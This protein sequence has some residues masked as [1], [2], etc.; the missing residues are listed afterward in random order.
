M[1]LQLGRL[2]VYRDDCE[3]VTV[4]LYSGGTKYIHLY[5]CKVFGVSFVPNTRIIFFFLFWVGGSNIAMEN[6]WAGPWSYKA[7]WSLC[8]WVHQS[9]GCFAAPLTLKGLII[10][11]VKKKKELYFWKVRGHGS[12]V[13]GRSLSAFDRRRPC[14]EKKSLVF[15]GI[16]NVIK[17]TKWKLSEVA[18]LVHA[19][20]SRSLHFYFLFFLLHLEA[21]ISL[22][23]CH[24]RKLL[25]NV[26]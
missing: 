7:I 11:F 3:K 13:R 18:S 17:I 10:I 19:I 20:N 1:Y 22:L 21:A 26:L 8:Y 2:C 23:L 5:I 12:G 16:I 24:F 25:P 4:N 14:K 9:Q 6:W 15:F